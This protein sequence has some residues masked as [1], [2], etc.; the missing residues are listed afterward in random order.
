MGTGI[1]KVHFKIHLL[2]DMLFFKIDV[3]W[4]GYTLDITCLVAILFKTKMWDD[5]GIP[6]NRFCRHRWKKTEAS[7]DS[8]IYLYLY[9]IS[10]CVSIH[11]YIHTSIHLCTCTSGPPHRTSLAEYFGV[12]GSGAREEMPSPASCLRCRGT[13]RISWSKP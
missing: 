4:Y 6:Q 2:D 13:K 8:Y 7:V 10:I 11:P 1:I 3:G 9:H 12:P 5:I